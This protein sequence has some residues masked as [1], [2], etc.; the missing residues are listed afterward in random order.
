MALGK[1]KAGHYIEKKP[2]KEKKNK[3]EVLSFEELPLDEYE[4]K[5][6]SGKKIK[7]DYKRILIVVLIIFAL[8]LSVFVFFN[9]GFRGCLSRKGSGD[10][11]SATVSGNFIDSG[12]F[13]IF[14]SGILY[15]SDTNI[16]SLD[17]KGNERFNVQHGFA[18][19]IVKT[20]GDK[21]IAYD[22]GSE[23]FKILGKSGIDFKASMGEKIYLADI[24]SGG[25]YAIVTEAKDYN[26]RLTAFNE[27]NKR[28]YTYSFA[29]YHITSMALNSQGSGAVV[30]GVSADNGLQTSI[31]YVLDFGSET[32]VAKHIVAEDLIYD[33]DYLS[34]DS[35]CAIGEEGAYI[36]C[37]SAYSYIEKISYNEMSLVAYDFNSDIGVV[38]FALSRSGDGS[39]CD[40]LYVNA[41]GEIENTINTDHSILSISTY[42]NRIAVSC[43]NEMFIYNNGGELCESYKCEAIKQ[44]RLN[45]TDSF[46]LLGLN[47]I[48]GVSL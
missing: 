47:G 43:V 29:D 21:A 16:V 23:D 38:A 40:I 12:N 32:P 15:S 27:E 10:S 8:V 13:R 18:K 25:N 4:K 39:N 22:L 11:F 46:Y 35:V 30:C 44:I 9:N 14:D 26:A 6:K 31:I 33:C 28:T 5:E 36:C 34:K 19:P 24:A 7:L 1:K 48:S 45:S 3:R 41:G 37:G 20:I 2:K 42:K 17:S